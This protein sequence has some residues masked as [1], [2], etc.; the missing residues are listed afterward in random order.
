MHLC[1]PSSGLAYRRSWAYGGGQREG[2]CVRV[3]LV[4]GDWE[5]MFPDFGLHPKVPAL[6]RTGSQLALFH[7]HSG[8]I[9]YLPCSIA[10][11][12]INTDLDAPGEAVG[13][14][15]LC[16]QQMGEQPKPVHFWERQFKKTRFELGLSDS[17]CQTNVRVLSLGLC[18]QWVQSH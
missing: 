7:Q 11:P 9:R 18:T 3:P 10:L 1:V 8:S 12:S 2:Q 6:A 14:A 17:T 5:P 4:Y 13:A 15:R 16:V